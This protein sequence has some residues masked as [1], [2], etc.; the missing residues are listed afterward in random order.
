VLGELFHY[1]QQQPSPPDAC[2]VKYT[3]KYLEP[4]SKIFENGLL[5]HDHVADVNSPILKN[6][7]EGYKFFRSWHHK[8]VATY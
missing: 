7:R 1:A 2:Q 3:L 5:S 8:Q 4:Y 6:I